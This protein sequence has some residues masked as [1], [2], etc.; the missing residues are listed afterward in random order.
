MTCQPKWTASGRMPTAEQTEN[1]PPTQSQK[2]NTL[3]GLMPSH[4]PHRYTDTHS[5]CV[6]VILTECRSFRDVGADGNHVAR[7]KCHT[8]AQHIGRIPY[9]VCQCVCVSVCVLVQQAGIQAGLQTAASLC[10]LR[11]S[12]SLMVR[13]LSIVSAVV[14]VLEMM[15]I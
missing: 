15:M 7:C 2:P 4:T 10:R 11:S 9:C 6:C 13:A 1:R 5:V 8:T 14:N 3:S 12:H